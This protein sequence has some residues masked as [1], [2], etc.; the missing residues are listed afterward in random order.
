MFNDIY[1]GYFGGITEV[2]KPHGKN[3]Y[4]YDVNYLYPAAALNPM[5]GSNCV[6]IHNLYDYNSDELFGFFLLKNR[7]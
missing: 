4:Y 3:L 7:N 5:P 2:Y 6:F 1:Q